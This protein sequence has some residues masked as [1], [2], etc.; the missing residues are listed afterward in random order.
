MLSILGSGA[1]VDFSQV[2]DLPA[3][4]IDIGIFSDQPI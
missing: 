2:G 1:P 4:S 3:T